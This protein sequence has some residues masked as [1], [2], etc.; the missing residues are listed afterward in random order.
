MNKTAVFRGNCIFNVSCT[1]GLS[2]TVN[3]FIKVKFQVKESYL[4]GGW[5]SKDILEMWQVPLAEN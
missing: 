4:S 5:L 1:S 3:F 2:L